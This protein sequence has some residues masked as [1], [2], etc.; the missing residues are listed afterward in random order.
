M[1][2]EPTVHQCTCLLG[3]T[4]IKQ[5]Q[6][7][8]N[9]GTAACQSSS[10]PAI[11]GQGDLM[12]CCHTVGSHIIGSLV[13][14]YLSRM[15]HPASTSEQGVVPQPRKS[16]DRHKYLVLEGCQTV[17]EVVPCVVPSCKRV[18]SQRVQE[19]PQRDQTGTEV[20]VLTNTR[21]TE[22]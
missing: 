11:A 6:Q 12:T 13:V 22:Q 17:L 5:T 1:G 10:W 20:P 2:H 3:A 16:L 7:M 18:K 9:T 8:M 21:L 4:S 19:S 15:Q 14:G